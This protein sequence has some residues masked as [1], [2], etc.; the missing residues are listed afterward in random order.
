MFQD[1]PSLP[2]TPSSVATAA[3][4]GRVRGEKRNSKWGDDRRTGVVVKP[5]R[6]VGEGQ[7]L[8]DEALQ[9]RAAGRLVRNLREAALAR[10][11]GFQADGHEGLGRG[12]CA[13]G[14]QVEQALA[15]VRRDDE[16]HASCRESRPAVLAAPCR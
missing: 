8:D 10:A 2:F 4:R 13:Q 16:A 14:R 12:G 9:L 7:A 5:D 1:M 15:L 6:L 3:V 11:P